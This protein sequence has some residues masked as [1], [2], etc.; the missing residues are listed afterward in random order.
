MLGKTISHYKVLE[1]IGQG[2][3]GEVYRA[4]DT[5]L[6]RDV[7][8]K[9]LPEQ[10]ASDS[11]RMGRFQREAEVLA[12]LDHPNIGQIYGIENAGQTKA[13]VLQLIE[14]PT[15]AER[16]AQGPIPVE[17][18]RKF[19]LQMAEGLEA[20]H[21][22]GVIHRDLKPANVKITPEGQVKILDFGLAK[23]LEAEAPDSSL[24]QSPTLT[25]AATQA[26][27]ILGTAAYMSPEQARGK[28]TDRR[29][30]IW[31]I[32]VVLFEMLS[33]KRAFEGEDVSQTL[34]AVIMTEP[35]WSLLPSATPGPILR[36][37]QRCLDREPHD[38]LQAIGEFRIAVSRYLADPVDPL[39]QSVADAVQAPQR[40][41]L[42]WLAA[43]ALATIVAVIA[44]W[45]LKPTEPQPLAPAT[46]FYHELPDSQIFTRAASLLVAVS[47]DG[48]QIVYGANRQ[49]YL[50]NLD[51]MEARPIQGTD[52]DPASP[53][54]S[55]G[56]EWVGYF[57]AA[58]RQLKK[59][60]PIGGASVTLC[61]AARPFGASWGSDDT[62]V[63]GQPEGIMRVSANGGTPELV[64]PTEAPEQVH[65]PQMLPGGEW[66]LFT[67]TSASGA[68]R[69]DEAQSV[70]QSLES[71][72]RKILWE[73]GSDARY[74]PTGHLVYALEDVLFALPFDLASLE[75]SGGPVPM[76]EGVRRTENPSSFTASANYGFSDGGTLIYI[77]GTAAL[78]QMRVLAL[79]DRNGLV[80]RFN[81]PPKQYL[82]PRLSPDG[83]TLLVQSVEGS[84]NIIWVYDLTGGTA[85]QQLTLEGNNHRPVWTPDSQRITFSSDRDGTMSLYWMPADGSG[86][87]ERLTTA[88]EG[89]SHWMGSWSPDGELLVFNVERALATDWDIWTLSVDDRETQSLYDTPGTIYMGAELSPNAEWLA[90]GAGPNSG[91]VDI[92]VEPF[93]PTGARR[94]ISQDGGYW[95]LWSPEG[96]ELFYRPVSTTAGITLRSVDIVTQPAF[97]FS[98]EQTLPI[99]GFNVVSYYRDYD[100]SSDGKRLL[101]VFPADQPD[102]G[103]PAGEQIN[104]VLNWFEELKERVPVP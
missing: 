103:E 81:L 51:E 91:A 61:D 70:A 43:I 100:M 23:A 13:L 93:P 46:R 88:E 35:D 101:M 2:G 72:E 68:A 34:A 59:I 52:E 45:N 66:V 79:V 83:Q 5:K 64:V 80:E 1:K 17:D 6:N 69:W 37:L 48:S 87:A 57:S 104:V 96:S 16:I 55:P 82:S 89:T 25:N 65:G 78:A 58:D 14:G 47:P 95:P 76:V 73:G 60:A 18:A 28:P 27:V 63:Y 67:L 74:L 50:R 77:P 75:V 38:R 92:Y 99:E 8:L 44:T 97:G 33:G 22:K 30:D 84:E 32:G 31:A 9:I 36:L 12:S 20:A 7:A 90:Y 10:F 102:I 85:I 39:A 54:F 86:V 11:Q 15:L 94:R 3:M 26:G 19:A 21:E 62:I 40:R 41:M 42:P 24:S 4:T 53:F 71:G 49:L 56:G 98:N 29:A